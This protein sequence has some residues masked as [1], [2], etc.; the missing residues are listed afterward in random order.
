MSE[1]DVETGTIF[2][3]EN[4]NP[5]LWFEFE[6]GGRVCLRICAGDDLRVIK[7]QSTKNKIEYRSGQ[8]ISYTVTDE[9]LEN[10]LLWDF[11]I[12][13]WENFF[14][15][16]KNPIPCT[17]DTKNLL[18]GKSIKFSRFISECLETLTAVEKDSE[19]KSEKN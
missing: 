14:D 18:M 12:V 2:C 3:L 4:L 8:R 11:C 13:N 10:S 15:A 19:E 17:P 5:G 6:N 9:D 7:K 16:N 1:N